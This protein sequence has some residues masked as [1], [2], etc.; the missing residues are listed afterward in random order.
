V[1]VGRIVGAALRRVGRRPRLATMLLRAPRPLP[2]AVR[3][4]LYRSYSWPLAKRL[5]AEC[6]VSVA[7]GSRLRVRTG[8]QIGR[9]L[10]VSGVWEPNVTA[11]FRSA[12]G[13]GDV[14]LDIGA[15]IGYFTLLASRLVGSAG[16]VYAFEPSPANYESLRANLSRNRATNVTALRFAVGE[17]QARALLR[18]APGTNTG[19]ATLRDVRPNRAPIGDAGVMVDVRPATDV[20]RE[21]DLRRIRVIKVDVE[22]YEVEVLRGLGPV[23]DLGDPL[24]LFVEFNP[25]WS[26]ADDAVRFLDELRREHGFALKRLGAGYTLETLFPATPAA[27]VDIA[28]VPPHECDLLLTR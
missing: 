23:L 21:G 24:A 11:A 4:R 7:G 1:T 2:P 19:R 20:I 27:P 12:L 15:H 13:P 16:H 14:C 22:G 6:V 8:D 10:A 9:V 25:E 3:A 5:G 28:E 17:A 26:G 18:A